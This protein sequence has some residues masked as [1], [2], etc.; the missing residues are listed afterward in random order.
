MK[1]TILLERQHRSLQQ[2]CDA[3]E[4]GSAKMRESLLPQLANDL[5]AHLKIEEEIFYPAADSLL[6]ERIWMRENYERHRRARAS[7]ARLMD[8]KTDDPEIDGRIASLREL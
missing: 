1:A 8:T 7:L 6:G 3:I 5:A 2:L 4:R